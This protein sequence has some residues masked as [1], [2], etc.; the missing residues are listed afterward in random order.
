MTD[1]FRILIAGF[2]GQGVLLC[3]RILANACIQKGYW[4]SWL[5]SYGPEMRGGVCNCRVVISEEK[6]INPIFSKAN[7]VIILNKDSAI[8]FAPSVRE[9]G[10]IIYNSSLVD[11]ATIINYHS[12]I[13]GIKATEIA[14]KLGNSAITNIVML[15][16]LIKYFD[17]VTLKDLEK[18]LKQTFK[19]ETLTL[20][21]KALLAGYNN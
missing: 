11:H 17:Y 2:G 14:K 19:G 8:K 18:S 13:K 10:I 4:T 9:N 3:G 5:P 20:N 7:I 6:I 12:N 1:E 21:I 15:G 16:K